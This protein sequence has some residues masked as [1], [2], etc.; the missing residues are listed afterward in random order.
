MSPSEPIIHHFCNIYN[1]TVFGDDCKVGSY[2]EI[3]GAKLGDRVSV[4]AYSFIPSGV[5]IE[6]DVIIGPGVHFTHE[7]P[8]KPKG[9]W[10]PILVKKGAMIG[11]KAIIMP[12]VTI[13][14]KTIIGAGAVVTK[15]VPAGETWAGVP[16][17]RIKPS[18][19]AL[20]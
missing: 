11:T 19:S 7:F 18:K 4:G 6:D 10:A 17:K 8:P 15:S 14:E 16:A 13:G 12:G 3:S 9:E 5:T 20:T 1:G 2:V